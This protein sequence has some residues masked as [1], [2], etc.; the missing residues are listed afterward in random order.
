MASL[1]P[2][3]TDIKMTLDGDLAVSGAGDLDLTDGF[4]WLAREVNKIVRTINPQWRVHPTI[5]AGVESFVGRNNDKETATDLRNEITDAIRRSKLLTA[6]SSITVDITPVAKDAISVYV[7]FQ[8]PG[9]SRQLLK[10]I[11]DYRSGVAVEVPD[12]NSGPLVD[13]TTRATATKNKYLS[14]IHGSS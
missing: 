9:I 8:A 1:F 2:S 6:G 13:R 11:V 4:D 14:R 7:N 5:G 12:D 3:K 10:L